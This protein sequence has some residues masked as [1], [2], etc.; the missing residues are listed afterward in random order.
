[1]GVIRRRTVGRACIVVV[2][3]VALVLPGYAFFHDRHGTAFLTGVHGKTVLQVF[4][5]L[6]GLYAFTFVTAQV[7]IA[8][9]LR[10]LTTLWPGVIRYHR[11]Q[12]TFALLFAVLHPLFI[13][14][15]FGLAS[16]L[17]NGF[18]RPGLARWTVPSYAALAILIFTVATALLAWSGRRLSWWRNVHR[19]NYLVFGL[20]WVHSW[21]IGTDTPTRLLRAVWILYAVLVVLSAAGRYRA[22][23]MT[24]SSARRSPMAT[25]T[26][27]AHRDG[28][29]LC[30]EREI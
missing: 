16:M 5:P 23:A 24:A 4:F 3:A 8:T 29:T 18:V 13:L 6:V 15:G 7:L 21:F 10:W 22:S 2:F 11:A 20:V 26:S 1:M 30:A 27:S 28:S 17:S 25:L 9:N 14:V 12:G 19:L